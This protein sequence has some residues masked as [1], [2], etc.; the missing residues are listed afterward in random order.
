MYSILIVDD[1]DP[2]LESYSYLIETSSEDFS[3]C[4]TARSGEEAIAIAHDKRPDVV[5]MDIAMPGIDGLDTIK[6]LQR[7]F[8][9][10]LYI[11]STAYERFDLAQRAIP[12]RVFSYLVKPVSRKRFLETL[13]LAK[14]RLD[15]KGDDLSHRLEEVQTNA[16]IVAREE[17]EF[18]LRTTWQ[19]M[20]EASWRRY[21]RIFK[22]SGDEGTIVVAMHDDS[23]RYRRIEHRVDLRYRSI[24]TEHL[25]MLLFFIS[26]KV[27]QSRL[28]ALVHEA[29]PDAQIGVGSRRRFDEFH[30]SSREALQAIREVMPNRGRQSRRLDRLSALRRAVAKSRTPEDA[31]QLCEE[32]WAAV[33]TENDI[34]TAKSYMVELF[35]LLVADLAHRTGATDVADTIPDIPSEIISISTKSDWDAWAGRVLALIVESNVMKNDTRRPRPLQQ[36]IHYISANYEQP[37]QLPSLAEYC[38]VSP[39]YLSRLF[40]EHLDTTFNDYLNSVRLTAAEE[41]LRENRKS[42]KEIAYE[43]GYHDP[44]YFSRIFKKFR[45][46]SP[47]SYQ[48]RYIHGH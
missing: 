18:L 33:F 38:S 37:L 20:D 48:E 40:S 16:E 41:L 35:T 9:E 34:E 29:V 24:F 1:E 10:T 46:L 45:G 12:L 25:G 3:L 14:D 27:E 39:G 28:E 2:V 21:Q 30:L 42:I 13:H 8:P 44:N 11:L 4:G 6:E 7:E 17:R 43:T 5:L 22:L 47:T 36:A 15:R 23:R 31:Y 32:Y 19:G 26:D